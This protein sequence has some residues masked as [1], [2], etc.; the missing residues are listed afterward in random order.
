MIKY[1]EPKAPGQQEPAKLVATTVR[2]YDLAEISKQVRTVMMG[3]AMIVRS[4][5]QHY[6]TLTML[7][8]T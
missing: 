7:Q 6:H 2:D 5:S 4:P 3:L 8:L 1:V